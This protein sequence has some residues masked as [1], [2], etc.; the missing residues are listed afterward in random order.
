M[1]SQAPTAP[2]S[3]PQS[4]T[5]ARSLT[6]STSCKLANSALDEVRRRVQ[7]QTLRH[8]G[9]KD[10]PLYRARKLLAAGH[11][12]ISE[13]GDAK[14]RGLLAAGDPHGEVRDA[15]HR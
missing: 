7:N 8:R 9:H 14:L 1:T 3:T 10:D 11:E 6:R 2:R 15:W 5:R 12:R 13:T 4:P